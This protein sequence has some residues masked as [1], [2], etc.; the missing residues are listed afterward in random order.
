M[1]E[2][3]DWAEECGDRPP[4]LLFQ[5]STVDIY[6]NLNNMI[7]N[8]QKKQQPHFHHQVTALQHR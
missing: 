2:A 8:K 1:E 5:K 6:M 4:H 3:P 7:E